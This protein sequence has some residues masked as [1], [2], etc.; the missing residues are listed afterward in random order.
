MK[1]IVHAEEERR[2]TLQ[3]EP[4]KE[5]EEERSKPMEVEKEPCDVFEFQP[6]VAS[7]VPQRQSMRQRRPARQEHDSPHQ[8][9][10]P[11]KKKRKVQRNWPKEGT[12]SDAIA[13]IVMEKLN[14]NYILQ[15][16][17]LRSTKP[18]EGMDKKMFV[19]DS[20]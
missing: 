9:S 20:V 13:M 16:S 19:V 2:K 1:N 17:I 18:T 12:C 7:T 14:A 8:L 5:I 11:V 3:Q 15:R 4:A 6:N 10:N